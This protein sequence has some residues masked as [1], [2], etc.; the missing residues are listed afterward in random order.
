MTYTVVYDPYAEQ[1]LTNIWLTAPNPQ[2][3]T[4]ASNLIDR[5]LRTHPDAVGQAYDGDHIF[6]VYPLT[7]VYRI[8]PADCRVRVLQVWHD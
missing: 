1:E 5:E 3:V 8:E 7:V 6:A 2:A 4:D